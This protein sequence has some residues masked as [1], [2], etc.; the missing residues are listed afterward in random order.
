MAASR[1]QDTLTKARQRMLERDLKGRGI[2]DPRVLK[3]MAEIPREEFLSDAYRPQA[4]DD[5]P[6][7]IGLGQTISQP[8]IVALMTQEL[9]VDSNCEVL[10][11][12]TG[13]GYQSAVLSRLVKKV[14]TIERFSQLS[15][16]AQAM[17]RRLGVSNI[18]FCVGD[19]SCGWPQDQLPPGGCFD[20]I[21]VTAAVPKIPEP[22]TNQLAEGGLIVMPVGYGALQDLVV[23]QNKKGTLI[24]RIVCS[25]RFVKL[26]GKYGFEG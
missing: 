5:G 11:V 1:D 3:A 22:L 12:G 16:S 4:Y 26:L 18:E 15:E 21:I 8:Y 13:S 9:H 2:T 14:Y 20:R 10:E 6:L 19:G 7:P 24:E 23:G 25:C 17:L